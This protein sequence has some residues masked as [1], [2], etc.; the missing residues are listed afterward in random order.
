MRI[1]F[2]MARET[3]VRRISYD[4]YARKHMFATCFNRMRKP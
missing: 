1:T 4:D 2:E 3:D